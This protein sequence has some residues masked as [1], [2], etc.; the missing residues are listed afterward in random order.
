[1][2]NPPMLP[3][4]WIVVVCKEL[5]GLLLKSGIYSVCHGFS[6]EIMSCW[7]LVVV[8][9]VDSVFLFCFVGSS[10]LFLSSVFIA[11]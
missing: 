4:F 1:M 3:L 5:S 10:R 11:G 9:L 6:G 7:L 2:F 8:G